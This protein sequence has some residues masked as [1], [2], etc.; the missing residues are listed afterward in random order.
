MNE[1]F[2][3]IFP[4]ETTHTASFRSGRQSD[5]LLETNDEIILCPHI[6]RSESGLSACM[7]QFPISSFGSLN[8][9]ALGDL[10]LDSKFSGAAAILFAASLVS[11]L[12]ADLPKTPPSKRACKWNGPLNKNTF[13]ILALYSVAVCVLF[14]IKTSYK[15]WF[16]IVCSFP[17]RSHS[18]CSNKY[19]THKAAIPFLYFTF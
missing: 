6:E 14:L 2:L 9:H 7:S 13:Q 10:W 4:T 18:R 15:I 17:S 1:R 16:R 12:R 11:V 8:C 19:Q 3:F 5:S